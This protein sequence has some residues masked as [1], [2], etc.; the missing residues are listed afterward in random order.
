MLCEIAVFFGLFFDDNEK[1]YKNAIDVYIELIKLQPNDYSF[2]ENVG[3]CYYILND[4]KNANIYFNKV[5]KNGIAKDGK[6]EFYNAISLF[7]LNQK[8]EGCNMLNDAQKK[9]YDIKMINQYKQIYC[10]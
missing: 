6:S 4:F 9:N 8:E 2:I 7:Q 3:I 10:K 5:I 1:K